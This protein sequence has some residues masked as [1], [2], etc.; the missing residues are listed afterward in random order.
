MQN[1]RKAAMTR[2]GI[3]SALVSTFAAILFFGSGAD[4]IEEFW[5]RAVAIAVVGFFAGVVCFI[6]GQT[7]GEKPR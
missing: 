7:F 5:P 1:S 6:Y 2:A 3:R 4:H